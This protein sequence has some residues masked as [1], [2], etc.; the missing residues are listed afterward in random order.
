MLVSKEQFVIGGDSRTRNEVIMKLFRLLG[1]SERQ[2][3]GGPLI[4]KT[5]IQNDFRR[6]EIVSDLQRTELKVWNIDLA[7]SYPELPYEEKQVLRL[8]AKS[9]QGISINNIKKSLDI[10]DYKVRKCVESLY[11]RNLVRKEGN[12]PSTR[13]CVGFESIEFL[14]Q[15]QI[16][17]DSLKKQMV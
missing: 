6:P 7:D 3:F 2:G 17:M 1:A 9:A 16:M 14:T 5:A 10:S 8:I 11:G 4:F 12:G 15:L 13:Y